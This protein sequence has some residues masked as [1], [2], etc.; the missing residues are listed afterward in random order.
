MIEI[1]QALQS[2][3]A[4]CRPTECVLR[5]TTESIG[6]VLAED[7]SAD[8]DSP[9]HDKALVD[10]FAVRS[11]DI[12]SQANAR[13]RVLE[14][15]VAGGV[16]SQAVVPGTAIQV[17]TGAPI[18]AGADAMVMVEDTQTSGDQVAIKVQN[19]RDGQGIL[20]RGAAFSS[21]E[22]VLPQGRQIRGIDVGLLSEVGRAQV[23]CY[24]RPTVAILPTGEELVPV[25][26]MPAMGKIRNSN[27]PMLH[28]M[29]QQ[30]A[31]ESRLLD[32]ARDDPDD[33]RRQVHAG[34]EAEVLVLTG[35]VS[36]GVRDLVP[37]VLA[38][39]GV[40]EVFHKVALKPGKPVWFG[41]AASADRR[42]LVFGLPGN[43]VSSLVCFQ[44]FVQT[45]IRQMTGQDPAPPWRSVQLQRPFRTSGRPTF[46]PAHC[47]RHDGDLMATPLDWCG[48]ADMVSVSRADCWLYF[49]QAHTQY[50]S[51]QVLQALA[52][53]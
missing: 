13:L 53:G 21:G 29:A 32:V 4:H 8:L 6:Y 15:V 52:I 20:R 42:T 30:T 24:A 9:P 50:Q 48:S 16:P 40:Q 1:D 35:G 7:V 38:A 45:A 26:T 14:Q 19:L 51:G 23:R 37:A 47:A 17:M 49:D 33:L 36:A 41:V 5:P 27:G 10:G 12:Q 34:L 43:P 3:I 22:L 2:V 11:Q 18:P 28:A 39:A 31:G 25:T 46:W 44:L